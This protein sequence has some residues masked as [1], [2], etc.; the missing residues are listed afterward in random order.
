MSK[1]TQ[2]TKALTKGKLV[3]VATGAASAF[4][5]AQANAAALDVSGVT[6]AI[7]ENVSSLNTVAVSVIGV[8]V[9][10]LVVNMIR[11]LVR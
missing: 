4:A 5:V 1:N 9:I 11:R 8:L 2:T 6:D 10:I 3:A 7:S